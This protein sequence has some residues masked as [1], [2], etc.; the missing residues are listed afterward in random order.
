[1]LRTEGEELRVERLIIMMAVIIHTVSPTDT[2]RFT[3]Y[4]VM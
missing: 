4:Y 3:I 1:M 2:S